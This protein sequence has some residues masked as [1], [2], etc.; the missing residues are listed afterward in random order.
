MEEMRLCCKR[1]KTT[2]TLRQK[3]TVWRRFRPTEAPGKVSLQPA[4]LSAGCAVCSRFP[5]LETVTHAEMGF[6][7]I[8]VFESL[9]L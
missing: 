3:R 5:A 6:G 4:E 8:A 2:K 9:L 7:D 1:D